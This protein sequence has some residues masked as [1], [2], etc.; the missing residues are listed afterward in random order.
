MN[1]KT[2]LLILI[3]LQG[4][5]LSQERQLTNTPSGTAPFLVFF[6]A[7]SDDADIIQPEVIE[8]RKEYADLHYSWEFGDLQ[9]P[10]W[11][12]SEKSKD[13]DIGYVTSHLYE[14][15]GTYTVQLTVDNGS[16][17]VHK[18]TQEITILDPNIEYA[19]ENTICFSNTGNFA[20]APA[21]A[22]TVELQDIT[23]L[24]DYFGNGKRLLL[25][26]GDSWET[27][28][29]CSLNGIQG[30]MHIGAY[31]EGIN[32][33]ERGIF[34]NAPIIKV[35]HAEGQSAFFSAS[36]SN[37]CTISDLHMIGDAEVGSSI[38]GSTDIFN[39]TINRMH[40]EGFRVGISLFHYNTDGHNGVRILN[41]HIHNSEA[42][43]I[44]VGSEKLVLQGN[45]LYEASLSHVVR[46]WQGYKAVIA[47]NV[48]HGSSAQNH[49]GRL[50][51]KYH[52]PRELEINVDSTI[53]LDKRSQYAVIYDN[54]FGTSGPWP[55]T[56]GPQNINYD[57]RIQDI[58]VEGNRF[59]AGWGTFSTGSALVSNGLRINANYVTVKNNIFDGTGSGQDY[60][61]CVITPTPTVSAS[62]NRVFN[63]T[64][65]KNDFEGG[66][67]SYRFARIYEGAANNKI[68]N[69][70]MLKAGQ[71]PASMQTCGDDGENTITKNNLL[72]EDV[73]NILDAE[74]SDIIQRDFRLLKNSPAINAGLAV[75][76]Y[77]DFLLNSR[78]K[79]SAI[80]I[81][82]HEFRD[83][84]PVD[85][86]TNLNK[87]SSS[88]TFHHNSSKN[89]L[90]I[91]YR[92]QSPSD[93]GIALLDA[94]GKVVRQLP[95]RAQPSGNYTLSLDTKGLSTGFYIAAIR[96]G[97]T[98][99]HAEKLFLIQ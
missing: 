24:A 65:F 51:L 81:G 77:Y 33:D 80:D 59:L 21:G 92:I 30:V 23:K 41:S 12:H 48:I 67:G 47:H 11:P 4:I 61:A 22:L 16:G 96:K 68:Y 76:V 10:N 43:I 28:G 25:R 73:T 54:I 55:V 32:P 56:I 9:S 46:I 60:F 63:N 64:S 57:E 15:P 99:V 75:P 89:S 27:T 88:Y 14:E 29:Y 42:N 7:L 84:T 82:A 78:E 6:D 97:E 98:L 86:I 17:T 52:G 58:L 18:Y 85:P 34:E 19:G 36:R 90:T 70:L 50:A 93:V 5:V 45:L 62:G 69:N 35:S 37:G 95:K 13:S 49:T 20:G 44:F 87:S 39:L 71:S 3:A 8:N 1:I 40:I 83:I 79:D 38:G 74:N 94:Q 91:G 31:G 26:R 66:S 72:L 53:H 2:V